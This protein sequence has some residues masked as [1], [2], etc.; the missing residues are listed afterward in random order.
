MD[1]APSV[2]SSGL[3][4]GPRVN[5]GGRIGKADLGARLLACATRMKPLHGGTLGRA[6]HE[7]REH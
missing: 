2:L 6:Q 1:T 5:A 7:R 4:L 3:C